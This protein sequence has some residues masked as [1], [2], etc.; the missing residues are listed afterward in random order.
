MRTKL[1]VFALLFLFGMVG[2]LSAGQAAMKMTTEVPAGISTP[3]KLETSIGVLTGFDGVPD[4][5]TIQKVY[6]QL[7]LQRATQAF[8]STIPIASM[9]AMEKGLLAFGPANSTALLFED[10]MDSKSLWLTPNTVSVYMAAWMEL[11]EEPMVIETPPNVL[12][13]I[14]D[15]WFH[16][17]VDFGNAGPDRGKGG[18]F[19]IVPPGYRKDVPSGYH[20]VRT[21]T[22][23]HWVVWR[24]FQVGGSPKPAVEATKKAFRIY[25]LSKKSNPPEMEFVNVSGTYHNTIH[26]MDFH[27]WEEIDA[28]IQAEPVQGLDPEIRG[29]LAAIGIEKGKEFAPGERMKKILTDAAKIGSVTARALTAVPRDQ[30]HY[31]YPGERVW[32]N[33]F[34]EGRYDFLMDGV[35]LLDSRIYMHFYATGITPAMAIKNVGKGSQ[36]AIAYLDKDGNALDGGKTYKINLP[37]DIPAKD[38]WSFTLYDN[39]TRAMLQTDQRFPGIDNLRGGLKQ[40]KDGSYDIYFS[41][42]PPNGQE[43]NWIQTV[44]GKGW[45]TILR[46]YGPLES[47]YDKTWKPGDPELID[48]SSL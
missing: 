45:N 9:Y 2:L 11:G 18:K 46:L 28:Q 14:N 41:P 26:S 37:K 3:D 44:P 39:Q 33:P 19:L 7:D 32:T 10:L 12:G 36:Y 29:L 34:I 25:P 20:T 23:G 30:R 6:D 17:V 15:A 8:L 5:A 47:F 35:R 38:F 4:A 1:S 31:L 16:Y 22:Y 27:F 21:E 43:N 13:F 48:S 42:K 40:G 24:G